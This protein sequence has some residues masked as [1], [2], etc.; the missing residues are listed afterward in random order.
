MVTSAKASPIAE[1]AFLQLDQE[2][3]IFRVRRWQIGGTYAGHQLFRGQLIN[4]QRRK[5]DDALV[6]FG[7]FEPFEG[8][9]DQACQCGECGRLFDEESAR[10]EHGRRAHNNGFINAQRE[11][12][13][14]DTEAAFLD[15]EVPFKKVGEQSPSIIIET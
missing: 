14:I 10:T 9:I 12:E 2:R 11:E 5:N 13:E 3:P 4:L 8:K 6:R 7:Y 15:R 1:N